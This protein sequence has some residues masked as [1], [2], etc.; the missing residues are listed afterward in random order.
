[1]CYYQDLCSVF[2]SVSLGPQVHSGKLFPVLSSVFEPP[3]G[4]SLSPHSAPYNQTGRE[5]HTHYIEDT[6]CLRRW[7]NYSICI[8]LSPLYP[9]YKVP[10]SHQLNESISGHLLVADDDFA[11]L[12]IAE[13]LEAFP[14]HVLG[15]AAWQVVDVKHLA[16]V[17]ATGKPWQQSG[18]KDN[19]EC[20]E[21]WQL[22]QEN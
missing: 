9:I 7:K 17:L 11:V 19:T 4:E 2:L 15:H 13:N 8:S 5:T 16:V 21:K 10:I 20:R 14:Q 6:F 18:Q 3:T 12:C 22:K 1:M